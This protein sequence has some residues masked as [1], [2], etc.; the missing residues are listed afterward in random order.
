[1]TSIGRTFR[2][3][4][5]KQTKCQMVLRF[6]MK[7][8]Y[9]VQY[10]SAIVSFYAFIRIFCKKS[11]LFNI[12]SYRNSEACNN[13]IE[14]IATCIKSQ[15]LTN[16]LIHYKIKHNENRSY[17]R[18]AIVKNLAPN[19]NLSYYMDLW[20]LGSKLWKNSCWTFFQ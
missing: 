20:T 6:K 12:L 10:N 15:I 19:V 16:F 2:S 11:N 8:L 17:S 18:G 4:K 14:Q 9:I 7:K 13:A 5:P 3:F 1:M